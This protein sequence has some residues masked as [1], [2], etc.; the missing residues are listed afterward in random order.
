MH[1][2]SSSLGRHRIANETVNSIAASPQVVTEQFHTCSMIL[3][4]IRIATSL[5]YLCSQLDVD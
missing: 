4:K 2:R 3:S 5:V 1:L